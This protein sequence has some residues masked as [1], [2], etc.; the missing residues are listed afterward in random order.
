MMDGTG[1][2]VRG[3]AAG[4]ELSLLMEEITCVLIQPKH[5]EHAGLQG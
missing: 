4:T 5:M 2:H 3:A 1:G